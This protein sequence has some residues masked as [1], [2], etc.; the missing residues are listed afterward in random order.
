LEDSRKAAFGHLRDLPFAV[1]K[2]RRRQRL[3]RRLVEA[4][5]ELLAALAIVAHQTLVQLVA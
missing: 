5:E 3:E 4:G 2:H 1:G